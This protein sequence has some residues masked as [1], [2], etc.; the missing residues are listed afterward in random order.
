MFSI[1]P[2]GKLAA[3]ALMLFLAA[4]VARAQGQDSPAPGQQAPGMRGEGRGRGE[5]PP[6]LI[7]KIAS[8]KD[9]ALELSTPDGSN[10]VVKLTDKTEFRK[11]RQPAKIGDFKVGDMV[12]VR[13]EQNADH[14]VTAGMV[15]ARSGGG[16]GGP[17]GQGAGRGFGGGAGFGEMGKDYVAGEIKSVD[18]PKITVLRTDNVKQTIELNEETSLRKGRDSIT[19]ADIQPGDHLVA[20]GSMQNNVFTPRNVMIVSPEQWQRMQE[21]MGGSRGAGQNANSGAKSN[22]QAP[23]PPQQ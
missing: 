10:V 20:R 13:G 19:M 6:P 17:G 18:A 12:F 9:G 7:G 21:F 5:G 2:S 3:L 4:G 14:S 15:A 22:A 11:D 16:P 23:A 1:T 8:I